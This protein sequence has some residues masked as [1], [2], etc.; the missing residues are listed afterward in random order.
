MYLSVVNH[1]TDTEKSHALSFTRG[2]MI[3]QDPALSVNAWRVQHQN[4]VYMIDPEGRGGEDL[5]QTNVL[6]RSGMNECRDITTKKEL[7]SVCRILSALV[8]LMYFYTLEQSWQAMSMRCSGRTRTV[9]LR[10]LTP[11]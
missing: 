1:T 6:G 2:G 10:T 4:R 11:A 3:P 9:S 5:N 8:R 7:S